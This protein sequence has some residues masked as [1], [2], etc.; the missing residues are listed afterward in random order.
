VKHHYAPDSRATDRTDGDAVACV[1]CGLPAVNRVHKDVP[2]DE[3]S[4]R[5]MGEQPRGDR[6]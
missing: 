3:V 1:V 2:V 5:V 4:P 6:K